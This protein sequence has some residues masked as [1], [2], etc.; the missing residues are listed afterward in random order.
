M[1]SNSTTITLLGHQLE[2]TLLLLVSL[3]P[4]M[5]TDDIVMARVRLTEA[6]AALGRLLTDR[7]AAVTTSKFGFA[8]PAAVY[9]VSP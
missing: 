3:S 1:D 9:L 5:S 4:R 6:G 7:C 8:P 2:T